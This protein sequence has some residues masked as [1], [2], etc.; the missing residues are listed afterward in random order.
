[1][2]RSNLIVALSS[3]ALLAVGAGRAASDSAA[4]PAEWMPH[5]MLVELRDLPKHYSCDDLWYKFRAILLAIGAEPNALEIRVYRCQDADARSPGVQ[6]RFGLPGTI[7]GLKP[8]QTSLLAVTKTIQ[9][10]PGKTQSLEAGDCELLKQIRDTL[11]ASLPVKVDDSNLN[12]AVPQREPSQF[13]LFVQ[14]LVPVESGET[15]AST[16]PPAQNQKR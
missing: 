6:L 8:D 2:K 5:S 3:V 7:P 13:G 1:M 11:L 14:A 9:L 15:S 10:A 12:C 16:S 4:Q